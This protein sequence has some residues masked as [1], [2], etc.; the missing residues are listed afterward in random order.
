MKESYQERFNGIKFS[1][2]DLESRTYEECDFKECS[3]IETNISEFS[4]IDC[5]FINCDLSS[6]NISDTAFQKVEFVSCKMLGLRFDSCKSFLFKITCK[7]SRLDFSSFSGM[8]LEGCT[9][10]DCQMNQVDFFQSNLIGIQLA[11]CDLKESIFSNS[12][13]EGVDFSSSRNYN[14]D[15][16]QN[17]IKKAIFSIEGILGL[18]SKYDIE[19]KY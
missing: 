4:F 11:N 8:K 7:E 18:L 15:P 2:K 13:L 16:D 9:F 6:V 17:K 14:I 3:F 1:Q 5:T 19:V 10:N 12:N